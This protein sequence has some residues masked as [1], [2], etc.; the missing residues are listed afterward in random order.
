M[1]NK[2][3]N[4]NIRQFNSLADKQNSIIQKMQKRMSML[5]HE[6]QAQSLLKKYQIPIP[7]VKNI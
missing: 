5:L 3:V 6:Y 1:F 2:V 7:K 4:K